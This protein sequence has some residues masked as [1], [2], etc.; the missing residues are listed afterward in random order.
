[1]KRGHERHREREDERV[2]LR[3]TCTSGVEQ[4]GEQIRLP[5]RPP[6]RENATARAS[7]SC[8]KTRSHCAT[9]QGAIQ[10]KTTNNIM[11]ERTGGYVLEIHDVRVGEHK[12]AREE[13]TLN[14]FRVS[15][16]RSN[17]A[18]QGTRPSLRCRLAR[19]TLP[20]ARCGRRVI[21]N[22]VGSETEI[23]HLRKQLHSA[24]T[25]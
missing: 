9:S 23:A 4:A 18:T 19:R 7:S 21:R 15:K 10:L 6:V 24:G 5:P 14:V 13:Q 22:N 8:S 1:M 3:S 16:R 20:A 11:N 12:R 17:G 25:T 2:E